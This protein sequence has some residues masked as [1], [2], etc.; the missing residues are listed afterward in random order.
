MAK[1]KKNISHRSSIIDIVLI[2]RYGYFKRTKYLNQ[3][4]YNCMQSNH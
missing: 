4:I 2:E 1:Q 3:I